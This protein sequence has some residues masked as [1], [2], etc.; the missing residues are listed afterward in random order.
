MDKA[1]FNVNNLTISFGGLLAVDNVSFKVKE[2][3]IPSVLKKVKKNG[4]TAF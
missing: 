3:T 2:K 4:Q 1:F